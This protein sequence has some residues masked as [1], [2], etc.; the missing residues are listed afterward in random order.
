MKAQT[1]ESLKA[2]SGGCRGPTGA[3]GGGEA[4]HGGGGEG[5][6]AMLA[7]CLLASKSSTTS[8]HLLTNTALLLQLAQTPITEVIRPEV[9]S[10]PPPRSPFPSTNVSC[11][12][13]LGRKRDAVTIT[14][15]RH[16]TGKTTRIMARRRPSPTQPNPRPGSTMSFTPQPAQSPACPLF[17]TPGNPGSIPSIRELACRGDTALQTANGGPGSG[18]R[19]VNALLPICPSPVP[20]SPAPGPFSPTSSLRTPDVCNLS[21]PGSEH[22]L[23]YWGRGAKGFERRG[24]KM[25]ELMQLTWVVAVEGSIRPVYP[26]KHTDETSWSNRPVNPTPQPPSITNHP[27]QACKTPTRHLHTRARRHSTRGPVA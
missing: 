19:K 24:C 20:R 6:S 10:A 16:W 2:S 1:I 12:V 17:H 9:A 27:S 14:A 4:P 3:K 21:L 26:N 22:P 7:S 5:L 13:E 8:H 11:A 15:N 25:N 18:K 23:A